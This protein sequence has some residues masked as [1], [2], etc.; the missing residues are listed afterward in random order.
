MAI[1]LKNSF[2]ITALNFIKN[3]VFSGGP[4]AKPGIIS[5]KDADTLESNI[6][7]FNHKEYLWRSMM[8]LVDLA[9]H[10]KKEGINLTDLM[11]ALRIKNYIKQLGAVDEEQVEQ[12]IARCANS[13]DPQKLVDVLDKIGHIDVPLGELENHIKLKH[14]EK[15]ELS[16]EINEARAILNSVNVDKRIIEDFKELKNEM[17]KYHLED[18][19]KIL[20]VLRALKK[21]KY[22]DK[23]IMAEFSV[24]RSMKKERIGIEFDRRR[25]RDDKKSKRCVAH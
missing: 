18:P 21:Y 17:D 9:I 25:L 23:R 10:C 7:S 6:D 15:E 20:N 4:R 2:N 22:D 24:R 3:L 1:Y 5:I 11:S 16:H 12:F 14:V 13:Q 8:I 19:K